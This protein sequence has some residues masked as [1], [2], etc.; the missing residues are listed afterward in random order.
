MKRRTPVTP[1]N[2][3]YLLR[4]QSVA[5]KGAAAL[6]AGVWT[7]KTDGRRCDF[8]AIFGVRTAANRAEMGT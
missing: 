4:Q 2:R 7:M 3:A 6:D 5:H 8:S 1:G